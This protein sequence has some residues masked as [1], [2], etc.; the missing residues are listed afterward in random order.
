M[1]LLGPD[2]NGWYALRGHFGDEAL[3]ALRTS[4]HIP[5]LSLTNMP[6]VSVRHAKAL[7]GLRSID[8]L[9]VWCSVT[10]PAMRHLVQ[11]PG[12]RQVDVLNL[13][14]PGRLAHF[15][16]ARNLAIFRANHCMIEDDLLG[17]AKCESIQ[18]LGAQ[19]SELTRKAL[20]SLMALP[21]LA[22]LDIEG[23]CFDDSMARQ[24]SQSTSIRALDIGAT[25]ITGR[26]LRHLAKMS[27]IRSLDLW[28]TRVSEDDLELLR[29]FP[30]LEY[31]SIGHVEGS[32][33]MDA[34]RVVSLLLELPSL[35]RVWLDGIKVGND[36]RQALE[37]RLDKVSI[38]A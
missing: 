19:G 13:V 4:D 12:L 29:E 16:R 22:N 25:Q 2:N 14:G 10:R 17:V 9:W 35:K 7:S 15:G 31:V 6:L 26:G 33:S 30:D 8:Q 34:Q 27:S 5:R 23:T 37:Q 11:L 20:S 36:Q 38:T 3:L 32:R 18:E 1:V 28:A 24:L 21:L